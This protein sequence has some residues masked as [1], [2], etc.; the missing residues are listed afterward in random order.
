MTPVER[1]THHISNLLVGGTGL[2]YAAMRYLMKPEDPYAI[3]HHPWQPHVQHLH[4][5]FA[6]LLVFAV[7]LSWQ[8][9]IA[10]RLRRRDMQRYRSGLTAVFT[11]VPMV[12]SGYLLQTTIDDNWRNLWVIVHVSSSILWLIGSV[13]HQLQPKEAPNAGAIP[14]RRPVFEIEP[15]L[16][17]KLDNGIV[18]MR[19]TKEDNT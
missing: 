19:L 6:P 17:L 12:L 15:D 11:L 1:W 18:E 8:R 3:V 5:V 16:D 4:I 9:H 13:A 7:G 14:A 10:P 2:V